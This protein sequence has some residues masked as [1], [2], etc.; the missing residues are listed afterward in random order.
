MQPRRN[1]Q[2]NLQRGASE[3]TRVKFAATAL[4]VLMAGLGLPSLLLAQERDRSVERVRAGLQRQSQPG[5]S[6]LTWTEPPPKKLGIFTLVSPREPGEM[7]RLRLPIGELVAKAAQGVSAANQRRR[8][9]SARHDVQ[10]AL[11]AFIAQQKTPSLS[12]G[13]IKE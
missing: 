2:T 10:K 8:E 6:V 1:G 12:N 5:S 9:T 3:E 4:G 11:T 13:P 7:V